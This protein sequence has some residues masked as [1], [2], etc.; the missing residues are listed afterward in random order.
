MSDWQYA[1]CPNYRDIDRFTTREDGDINEPTPAGKI[2]QTLEKNG[3]LRYV[4][5][6]NGVSDWVD[7]RD[8]DGWE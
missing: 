3:S 8:V 2:T 7:Y 4:V 5:Y 6:E 1:T